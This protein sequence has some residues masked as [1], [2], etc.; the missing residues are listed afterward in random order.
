MR[1]PLSALPILIHRILTAPLRGQI[2]VSCPF[3]VKTTRHRGLHEFVQDPTPRESQRRNLTPD[4][5]A[6]G[7]E[8]CT[9]PGHGGEEG[10]V[11]IHILTG[12]SG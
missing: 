4:S 3:K 5:G 6:H 11:S 7:P 12:E 8:P 10:Y 9:V 1:Q 2:C